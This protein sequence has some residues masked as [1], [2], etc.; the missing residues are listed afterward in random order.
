MDSTLPLTA[1][2][3]VARMKWAEVHILNPDGPDGFKF[4]WRDM[5]RPPQLY[6]QRQNGEG[7]VMVWGVSAEDKSKLVFL[8][9]RQN[10]G[11][12]IYTISEYML[13]FAHPNHGTD[14]VVQ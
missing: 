12:Y 2:H 9:D 7:S 8:K 13:P 6:Q 10:S 5:G 1:A 4:F 11:D 3:K 14:F